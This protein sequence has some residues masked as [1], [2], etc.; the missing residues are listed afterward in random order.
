MKIVI[1]VQDGKVLSV[2]GSVDAVEV[3]V[4]ENLN[5]RKLTDEEEDAMELEVAS[6]PYILYRA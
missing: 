2:Y 3:K 5:D 4:Y 1:E 6:V